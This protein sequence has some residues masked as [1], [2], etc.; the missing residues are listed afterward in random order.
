MLDAIRAARRRI[1]LETYIY[2]EGEI[3]DRFT[4]ALESAA[5]RGVVVTVV[6]DAFGSNRMPS[7]AWRRL[8]DAG[9][10]LGDYGTPTWYKLQQINYRTHR[11]ILVVDGRV[12][13]TGGAGI[14]DHWI[15]H[16]DH[17]DHWRDTMVRVEGPLVRLIEGAFDENMVRTLTPAK[18]IVE[19]AAR[20]EPVGTTGRG[21]SGFV[22]RSSTGGSNELK[23]TYMVAIAAARR[24]LDV[25]SP[26]FLTDR[27][28]RWAIDQAVKRGV[29]IRILTEGD[30]TD[31]R[32]V[33]YASRAKYDWLLSLGVEV[34]E[35][36]PTMM[37]AKAFVVDGTWSMV[38]SANFD[39]RS[40]EMNDEMNLA[41]ADRGLAARLTQ[42]FERDIRESTKLE[43]DTWRRRPWLEKVRELVWTYFGEVF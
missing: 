16:A 10:R 14:G 37:H 31:S 24:T 3:G 27:S 36:R 15:G 6:V 4:D 17:P 1:D 11:K 42:D 38:G 18:P 12:A 23:R 19:P 33:K 20:D 5:R 34:Y 9:A 35:Y 25:C 8:K 26:Y 41:V 21:D 7:G 22:I 43:L 39:N 2:S 32:I 30:R 28:S 13:F 29:H 40:L